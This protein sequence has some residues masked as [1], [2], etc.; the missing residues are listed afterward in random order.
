MPELMPSPPAPPRRGRLIKWLV[1][2]ALLLGVAW[3]WTHRF[4][5]PED[6]DH[7]EAQFKY[8]SIGAD[9]PM[10][11]APIPY[12][13]WKAM[14]RLLEPD[15]SFGAGLSPYSGNKG[16]AAFGLVS[17]SLA[18]RTR[19][20]HPQ[21]PALG[22]PS[23]WKQGDVPFERPIGFSRRRV[24]GMDFVGLNCAFCHL[25][26][27]KVAASDKAHVILGGVGNTVDI[28][29][30]FLYLFRSLDND[31]LTGERLMQAVDVELKL[32]HAEL[33]WF[34]RLIYR[35]LLVPGLR[36]YVHGL[37]LSRFDFIFPQSSTRLPDFGPG[38]VD[39]WGLYKRVFVDPPVHDSISG[40]SDFPPLWNQKARSGMRMHWDGNTDVLIERNVV[41]ALSL[42]GKRIDYLDFDRL[43]R[44]TD[45][46]EGL[47]P[48]RYGD[49]IANT[50][51]LD[52]AKVNRGKALFDE[53][54][55]RCHAPYGD[56]VGR[57]EPA[58]EL[59]TDRERFNEFSPALRDALNKLGTDKWQLRHFRV[60]NGYVNSLLDGVWLRAP[61]LHNGSVPT[62]R[63]L[64]NVPDQRP[65]KF[66]RGTN[67]YDARNVGFVSATTLDNRQESC[68][69]TFLYDTTP[70]KE[71]LPN[72]RSNGG[73]LYGTGLAE[74]EKEALLEYL[75][76]L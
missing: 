44:I 49:F 70:A 76:T 38:R 21:L 19:Q 56:R 1:V 74:G 68:P 27:L 39:T 2:A 25:G 9:H 63:D 18:E 30:Y 55:A 6:F 52:S 22:M 20:P 75:K 51:P 26:T 10:A 41:S 7:M 69:G 73:H 67:L 29:K 14:P 8:G 17:E 24:F 32:Q 65:R 33:G 40:T 72:G 62:L 66:C 5:T 35:W 36:W 12:W 43:L 16:W 37:E 45:W 50:V 60:E 59:G 53:Q 34:Q 28:E 57:V 15:D 46:I 13:M 47:V 64:L 61:Y 42:I 3:A 48:P 54:C 71:G 58:D 11:Q 23:G 4:G 31:K